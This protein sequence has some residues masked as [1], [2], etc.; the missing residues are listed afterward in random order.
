MKG[1]DLSSSR[2]KAKLI[3]IADKLFDASD[4]GIINS[5]QIRSEISKTVASAPTHDAIAGVLRR[6]RDID[7]VFFRRAYY[8]RKRK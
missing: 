7:S 4:D 6:C 8:F 3:Y 2:G 1:L 5:I